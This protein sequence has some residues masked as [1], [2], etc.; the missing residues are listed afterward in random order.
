MPGNHTK[1]LVVLH[2]VCLVK[3]LCQKR[4][5]DAKSTRKVG[6]VLPPF[7]QKALDQLLLVE[8]GLL[9]AALLQ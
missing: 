8:S 1:F 2:I 9:A 6:H 4:E 7:R 5:V 3:D